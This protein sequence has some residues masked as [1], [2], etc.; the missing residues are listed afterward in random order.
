MSNYKYLK[1]SS[2]H[3]NCSGCKKR[4]YN[5]YD[6]GFCETCTIAMKGCLSDNFFHPCPKCDQH[7]VWWFKPCEKED[8]GRHDIT[9]TYDNTGKVDFSHLIT[10]TNYINCTKCNKRTSAYYRNGLCE[11]CLI[12]GKTGYP[13]GLSA[14]IPCKL[15]SEPVIKW[16]DEEEQIHSKVM[17]NCGDHEEDDDEYGFNMFE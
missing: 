10:K 2:P 6:Y 5:Y 9:T 4:I 17:T 7:N 3:I 12:I 16:F 11:D 14:Y 13:T 1:T 8:C 15:C